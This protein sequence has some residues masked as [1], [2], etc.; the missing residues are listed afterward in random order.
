MV[1]YLILPEVVVDRGFSLQGPDEVRVGCMKVL[2]LWGR[3]GME[4]WHDKTNNFLNQYS[5][6]SQC[7]VPRMVWFWKQDVIMVGRDHFRS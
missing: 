3:C 4:V 5:I 6:W 1:H 7:Q 2:G